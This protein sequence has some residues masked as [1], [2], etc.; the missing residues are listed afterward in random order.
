MFV[1]DG[2]DVSE[3]A[4]G[5]CPALSPSQDEPAPIPTNPRPRSSSGY[6]LPR[7]KQTN[8]ISRGVTGRSRHRSRTKTFEEAELSDL[9]KETVSDL[10]CMSDVP[11]VDQTSSIEVEQEPFKVVQK[12]SQISNVESKDVDE[13]AGQGKSKR[14]KSKGK[15]LALR[16]SKRSKQAPVVHSDEEDNNTETVKLDKMAAESETV[17]LGD[18]SAESEKKSAAAP[19]EGEIVPS[20]RLCHQ[21]TLL[22]T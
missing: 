16:K 19:E 15:S 17:K 21:D 4:P 22:L 5:R 2:A 3:E 13:D 18:L 9:A 14:S 8:D 12:I 10:A 7:A 11:F 20:D 1:T 6:S